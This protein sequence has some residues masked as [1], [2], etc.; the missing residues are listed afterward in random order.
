MTLFPAKITVLSTLLLLLILLSGFA[1]AEDKIIQVRNGYV[2]TSAYGENLSGGE[3]LKSKQVEF[4]ELGLRSKLEVIITENIPIAGDFIMVI[5]SLAMTFGLTS[6]FGCKYISKKTILKNEIRNDIFK[7][8]KKNPGINFS[9]I[10]KELGITKTMV[11]YHLEKLVSFGIIRRFSE[12]GR[13]GYF[14]NNDT[15]TVS[16]MKLSLVQKNLKDKLILDILT[17]Q[18]GITRKEISCKTDLSGPAI[19][20]HMKRLEKTGYIEIVRDGRNTR[21]FLKQNPEIAKADE[22]YSIFKS[23]LLNQ[24]FDQGE[25][26]NE[27]K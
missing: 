8:I 14:K 26:I 9:G 16:E 5:I 27:T 6:Y 21:Y 13:I 25:I 7:I 22:E 23:G 10:V 18:P 3:E 11:K 19:T 17:T 20:W 1:S 2:V 24:T 15:F 4:S 12:N